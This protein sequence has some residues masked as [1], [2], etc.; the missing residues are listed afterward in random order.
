MNAWN[1]YHEKLGRKRSACTNHML[2][3]N[4]I[5]K[6][7][8]ASCLLA[9]AQ[10]KLGK[11]NNSSTRMSIK[12]HVIRIHTLKDK[13]MNAAFMFLCTAMYP[14]KEMPRPLPCGLS[15]DALVTL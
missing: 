1:R 12:P 13:I 5:N 14:R 3:R 6:K 7:A 15:S 10:V 11:Y 8:F 4:V 9:C 2:A